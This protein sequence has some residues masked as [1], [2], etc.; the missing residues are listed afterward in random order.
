MLL[1]KQNEFVV[2]SG[3]MRNAHGHKIVSVFTSMTQML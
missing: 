3:L 1:I 2:G